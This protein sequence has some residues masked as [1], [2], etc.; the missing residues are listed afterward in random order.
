MKNKNKP[1]TNIYRQHRRRD[2]KSSNHRP[3]CHFLGAG[4]HLRRWVA[5][6]HRPGLLHGT[7]GP[8]IRRPIPEHPGLGHRAARGADLL[9]RDGQ[10]RRH[11]LRRVRLHHHELCL[12]HGPAGRQPHH[13]GLLP[14]RDAARVKRVVQDLEAYRHPRPRR[15][16]VHAHLHRD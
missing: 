11:L 14:R 12:H 16:A 15:V 9:Q 3:N 8:D 5:L 10:A 2:Q 6:H 1:L 4:L 13:L 7:P